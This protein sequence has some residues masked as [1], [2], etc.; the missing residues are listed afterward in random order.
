[1]T[2]RQYE[3]FLKT[4][5]CAS[6]S[7]AAQALGVSQS[8]LTQLLA[9]LERDCGFPL[10]VRNR[11]GVHL[12]PAG[13]ALLPAVQQVC[14][15]DAHLR[16]RIQEVR[17]RAGGTI[18]IAT[19]EEP[20]GGQLAAADDQAVSG[21]A[22]GGA[23]PPV[24][25]GRTP[26]WTP[27]CAAARWTWAS[28]RCRASCRARSCPCAAT[29]CWPCCRRATR[30]RRARPCPSRPSARYRSVSLIDSTNRDALRVLDAAHVHPDIRFQ[31]ADDYAMISMV[32][33]GLG[34]CIAHELVLRSDHHN[35]VVRPLDPPAHRTI[36]MAIPPESEG[37][38]LVRT[39]AAF[40]RA[41]GAGQPVTGNDPAHIKKPGRSDGSVPVFVSGAY[42]FQV[43][44]CSRSQSAHGSMPS[45]LSA[46]IG[47][48]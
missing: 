23:L 32:E 35:V 20:R 36:A 22:S 33:S 31:T 48:T 40:V 15:A 19:F 8:A 47:N 25:T 42:A 29:G 6:V 1:M 2:L 7:A 46:E 17:E 18:R 10:L 14:A 38:P 4:V 45:P 11:G 37:K 27:T 26:R 39:F 16:G 13:K 21:A 12:T 44:V 28:S 30:W 9:G 34:I 3:A 43:F 24:R 41:V 5:E